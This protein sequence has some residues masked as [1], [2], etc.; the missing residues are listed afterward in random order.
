MEIEI[1]TFKKLESLIILPRCCND[2]MRVGIGQHLE[3]FS[4]MFNEEGLKKIGRFVDKLAILCNIA[5]LLRVDSHIY[6]I[7][8]FVSFKV[9]ILDLRVDYGKLKNI[10]DVNTPICNVNIFL[11]EIEHNL[12]TER[13]KFS[14]E[15][16]SKYQKQFYVFFV[17]DEELS[18]YMNTQSKKLLSLK[19]K[20]PEAIMNMIRTQ[21]LIDEFLT[22]FKDGDDDFM[23]KIELERRAFDLMLRSNYETPRII[24]SKIVVSKFPSLIRQFE[25]EYEKAVEEGFKRDKERR[26]KDESVESEAEKRRK[27]YSERME[28]NQKSDGSPRTTPKEKSSWWKKGGKTT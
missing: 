28:K 2:E 24:I 14:F 13:L 26:E 7:E 3:Q 17:I 27:E 4:G 12:E 21:K 11:E 23:K 16:S 19:E 8:D 6:G 15:K 1:N 10:I 20:S 5:I 22:E 9:A 25:I 18:Q